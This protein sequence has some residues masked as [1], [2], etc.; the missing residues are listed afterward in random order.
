MV[1]WTQPT[2]TTV[3]TQVLTDLDDRLDECAI[4]FDGT[5]STNI[6]TGAIRIDT[7]DLYK[8]ERYGGATWDAMDLTVTGSLDVLNN[9]LSISHSWGQLAILQSDG[10]DP[11]DYFLWSYD[12]TNLDIS[13]YDDSATS[14]QLCARYAIVGAVTLYYNNTLKLATTNVGID[15]TGTITATSTINAP[16]GTTAI[17][18]INIAEG[19][20][21]SAPVD[22]DVWITTTDAFIRINGVSESI[23]ASGGVPGGSNTQIQFND[24]S[25]FGGDSDFTWNKTTNSLGLASCHIDATTELQFHTNGNLGLTIT[26]GQHVVLEATKRVYFDGGTDTFIDEISANNLRMVIGGTEEFRITTTTTEFF[27]NSFTIGNDTASVILYLDASSIGDASIVFQNNDVDKARIL[28]DYSATGISV[29]VNSTGTILVTETATEILNE[30]VLTEYSEEAVSLGG[31]AIDVTTGTYFYKTISG[32][33]TFTFTNPAASGRVSSFTLEL[34]NPSTNV[35]WPISVD[36]GAGTAPTLTTTGVDI[37][38]FVTRDAGT[39]WH[40]F[41]ASL[42]SS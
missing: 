30:A 32:A 5:T 39:T 28:W 1:D 29:T 4:M 38:T 21:R 23:I 8:L 18:S 3:Y 24:S 10:T 19:V 6:P 25:V 40:G 42:D 22:G 34:T 17:S 35:T 12:S 9:R 16:A 7:S 2:I 14:Y 33:T 13:F 15:V 27:N 37:L 31:T 41:L 26:S 36:W 20:A 11:L